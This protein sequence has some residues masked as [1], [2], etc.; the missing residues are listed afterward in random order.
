MT[1]RRRFSSRRSLGAV[2]RRIVI[3]TLAAALAAGGGALWFGSGADHLDPP[4]G[5]MWWV[6]F[7]DDGTGCGGVIVKEKWVLT[8]AHCILKGSPT[9]P[10]FVYS[11]SRWGKKGTK[12]GVFSGKVHRAPGYSA[13]PDNNDLALINVENLKLGPKAVAIMLASVAD[14]VGVSKGFATG[15]TCGR[16]SCDKMIY[17]VVDIKAFSACV[18]GHPN[19]ICADRGANPNDSGSSLTTEI[20][21]CAKLLGIARSAGAGDDYSRVSQHAEWINT[22]IGGQLETPP[23]C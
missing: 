19:H 21:G 12:M 2:S 17:R 1:I 3:G 14:E 9:A 4:P 6:V 16:S 18:G 11:G 20:N 8:A 15:W 5:S 22:T 23:G 13:D 10:V 7:V